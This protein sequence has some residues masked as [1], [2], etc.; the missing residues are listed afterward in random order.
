MCKVTAHGWP[1]III[2][3]IDRPIHGF[4]PGIYVGSQAALPDAAA[5]PAHAR[6]CMLMQRSSAG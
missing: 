3:A 6:S 4:L 5:M 2:D 1:G